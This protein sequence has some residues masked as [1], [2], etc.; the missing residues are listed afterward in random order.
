M[1]TGYIHPF[2]PL[3]GAKYIT[4]PLPFNYRVRP[5]RNANGR[6]LSMVTPMHTAASEPNTESLTP[7][8][9]MVHET[10]QVFRHPKA[11]DVHCSRM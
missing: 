8:L 7:S 6:E 9:A 4:P 2:P 11:L 3:V 10:P 1:F 5:H